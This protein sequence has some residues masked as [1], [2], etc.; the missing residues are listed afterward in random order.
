MNRWVRCTFSHQSRLRAGTHLLKAWVGDATAIYREVKQ[1]NADA[2]AVVVHTPGFW[3]TGI[4]K[5][6]QSNYCRDLFEQRGLFQGEFSSPAAS[7][8]LGGGVVT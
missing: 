6:G 8:Y 2:E 4:Q 3:D 7:E 5:R 1:S